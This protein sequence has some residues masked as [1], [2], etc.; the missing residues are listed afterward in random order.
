MA[1]AA[2]AAGDGLRWG[3]LGT[4]NIARQ[5]AAGVADSPRA[6]LAF[7]GSRSRGAA[8]AFVAALAGGGR[9]V[10]VGSY[11]DLI[12]SRDVDAVYVSLPNNLHH[13]WTIRALRAGK[14]VLCEKPFAANA[15]QAQ[16]MF[17]VAR[18]AGRVVVEAFMYRSHPQTHA[19][20]RAVRE[21]AIG[22]LKLIRTS[23]CFRTSKVAGNIRF[24]PRLAGGSVMDV[25][26]YCVSF[27]RL[28]AGSEP[29]GI[30]AIGHVHETGVD[31]LAAGTL[32]FEHG[33]IA[34]VNCGMAVQTDNSALVCGSEGY[35]Q[36][37]VPWKPPA[38]GSQIHIVRQTPPLMDG[39]ARPTA[40]P[41][42]TITIPGGRNLYAYEIDDFAA[43]VIDGSPPAVTSADTIGNMRVLDEIRR[44]IGLAY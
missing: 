28:F 41:R 34:L 13:E 9:D 16:E 44:Q 18:T 40:P 14:H 1:A 3:V 29:T 24:D 37:P 26:C 11:E 33:P 32:T 10:A 4:G 30:H 15:A 38:D 31:D 2:A 35:I 6:S 7:V 17:D 23:F 36:I 27:A 20:V 19:A 43:A 8:E 25:G 39:V 5:F 21:G 42:E 22:E 12:A